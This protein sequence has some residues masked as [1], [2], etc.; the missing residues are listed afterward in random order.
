MSAPV[1]DLLA[2]QDPGGS[3]R[4]HSAT[5]AARLRLGPI[6]PHEPPLDDRQ[7]TLQLVPTCAPQL[8]LPLRIPPATP[9]HDPLFGP[10]ITDRQDLPEPAPWG[11]RLLQAVL[12]SLAGR[13]SPTQLQSW[14]SWGVYR[15][16]VRVAQSSGQRR[17]SAALRAEGVTIARI[18]VC[19]PA[20]GVAE[21]CAVARWDGRWHAVAARLEGIDG[22]WRC[23]SLT[24]G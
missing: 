20:D 15:D 12:E 3:G 5:G 2:G 11:R 23:V 4:P 18:R 16:I 22:R 13:R 7:G 10:Q 19:E 24:V 21:V 6:P 17:G 14:T 8:A 1:I 9:D